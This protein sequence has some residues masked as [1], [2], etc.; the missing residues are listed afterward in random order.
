MQPTQP[1]TASEAKDRLQALPGWQLDSDAKSIR[2]EYR[3]D[4]FMAAV[5]L[6]NQI[7]QIAQ[8]ENHHPDLHLVNYKN[9]QVVLSTHKIKGLSEFDFIVAERISTIKS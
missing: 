8:A 7:A 2:V 1:M 9:I 5:R 3:M 4:D 6:I